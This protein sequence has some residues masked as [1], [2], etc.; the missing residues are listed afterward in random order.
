MGFLDKLKSTAGNA[1][2]AASDAA[3]NVAGVGFAIY[4]VRKTDFDTPTLS[5]VCKG[6]RLVSSCPICV[7]WDCAVGLSLAAARRVVPRRQEW[8]KSR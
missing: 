4:G 2:A 8:G 5:S 7:E 3:R 1:M 6:S